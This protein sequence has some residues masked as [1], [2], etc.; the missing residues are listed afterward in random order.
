MLNTPQASQVQTTFQIKF[1]DFFSSKPVEIP[2]FPFPEAPSQKSGVIL[3]PSL[4]LTHL[5]QCHG[6]QASEV[7]KSEGYSFPFSP[8]YSIACLASTTSVV[9]RIPAIGHLRPFSPFPNVLP[10]VT[11]VTFPK[12]RI[13]PGCSTSHLSVSSHFGRSQTSVQ[14]QLSGCVQ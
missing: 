11:N 14:G 2:R 9:W 8:L 13:L 6:I 7:L 3:G 5:I 10:I 1:N 4:S 12:Q